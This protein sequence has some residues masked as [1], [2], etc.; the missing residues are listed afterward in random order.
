MKKIVLTL[1]LSLSLSVV[2]CP[3][4]GL[5]LLQELERE[6]IGILED[7]KDSV[8][9][10]IVSKEIGPGG[11][12]SGSSR[13]P[14]FTEDSDYRNYQFENRI[15]SGIIFDKEGHII[16]TAEVVR[17]AI[18]ILVQTREGEES[19]AR[20]V[21]LDEYSNIAVIQAE[22]LDTENPTWGNSDDIHPGSWVI[23]VGS[24]Y[25]P[26]ESVAFGMVSARSSF[27]GRL[28]PFSD[29]IQM[30]IGIGP[31]DSGGAILNSSGEVVGLTTAVL[32]GSSEIREEIGFAL[33]SNRIKK[34]ADELIVKG[35]IIRGWLGINVLPSK[36]GI[37]IDGT[38]LK[39]LKVQK[40]LQDSPGDK[41]GLKAN[42]LILEFAGEKTSNLDTF[43]NLVQRIPIGTDTS[44]KI[45]RNGTAKEL[46]VRITESPR[47]SRITEPLPLNEEEKQE[48]ELMN[49][50]ELAFGKRVFIDYSNADRQK[51]RQMAHF[52]WSHYPKAAREEINRRREYVLKNFSIPGKT[53]SA[54]DKG[55]IYLQYG[56]PD[57]IKTT[58]LNRGARWFMS[59]GSESDTWYY[60]DRGLAFQFNSTNDFLHGNKL[61]STIHLK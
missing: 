37:H 23:S 58:K 24:S 6:C 40:V 41:A 32:E 39:G 13:S 20:L 3:A 12:F 45:L 27:M 16:T 25:G 31:G 9:N 42:D 17:D 46:T 1:L 55:R 53:G 21:G 44:V 59:D 29:Y 34:I 18:Q 51:R 48:L 61:S 15:G 60:M 4:W 28:G 33:P 2:A 30:N 5:S 43:Q 56:E 38:R 14:S 52:F 47:T 8:V 11:V 36:A 10:I 57:E 54:T 26:V 19:G 50:A 22:E 35:E 49:F 7:T